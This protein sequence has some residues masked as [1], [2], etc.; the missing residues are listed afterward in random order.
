MDETPATTAIRRGYLFA[1]GLALLAAVLGVA[2]P[3][4][5]GEPVPGGRSTIILV[6][7]AAVMIFVVAALRLRGVTAGPTAE[8]VAA[9][10][11]LRKM[12]LVWLLLA[13]LLGAAV[14]RAPA[15]ALWTGGPAALDARQ[16]LAA[17]AGAVIAVAALL[18]GLTLLR[19]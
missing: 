13:G 15:L 9:S 2:A 10:S 12:T 8:D 14:A 16:W 7:L 11:R 3:S 5:D 1:C 19:R 4:P 6:A 17:A 18:R